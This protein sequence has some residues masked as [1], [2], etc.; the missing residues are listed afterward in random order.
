MSGHSKWAQI[1]RKKEKVDTQRGR[2][3]THLIREITVAARQGGGNPETNARLRA[4]I[5]MAKAQN[6]PQDNIKN[7][8]MRGTGEL[9]GVNYEE[10]SYEGYGS[11]GIAILIEAV[12]DNKNR[13][14]SEIRHIFSRYG[15]NLGETG[16]VSWM[17][18]D[19][20]VI[21]ID[22]EKVDEERLLMIALDAGAEDVT[23]ESDSY[24]IITSLREFGS[25]RSM[26]ES[27]GVEYSSAELTKLPQSTVKVSE[28][29]AKTILKLMDA[30]EEH[31]DVQHVYANFD[32]PDEI[33]SE[34]T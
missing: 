29:D 10:I 31:D 2:I 15:G 32:I 16:C 18:K 12:T 23:V 33:L 7:A 22:K 27:E 11:C 34:T 25:V 20:G 30:L 19:K 5:D 3:F 6:M 24:Q 4:A 1:R 8:I 14:T 21:Y 17:F 13:T 9:E 26:L 28:K